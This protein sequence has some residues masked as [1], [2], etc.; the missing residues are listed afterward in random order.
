[1]QRQIKVLIVDDED[2][3]RITMVKRLIKR[4]FDADAA[5]DCG[6][7]LEKLETMAADV[8]F[9]DVK[10]Q[11][12]DGLECLKLIK[13]KRPHTAVIMLT[14]HASITAGVEGMKLGAFD[15]CIK[16]ID[17]GRLLERIQMACRIR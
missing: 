16:P 9:L 4:G 6:E 8:V 3:F 7:A 11:S 5:G 10:M 17:L 2:D 1:M 13:K 12:M 15:Y 14:A